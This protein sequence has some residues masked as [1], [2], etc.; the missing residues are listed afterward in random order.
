MKKAIVV[1]DMQNDF[2]TGA[3]RNEDA[4]KMIPRAVAKLKA[5]KKE[6]LPII[7]TRDTHS[8]EG[9]MSSEE[10][11]NLPLP[12]CL[13]GEEGWEI[14]PELKPFTKDA[15]VIDKPGFGSTEL[16]EYL[17]QQDYEEIEMFGLC[18]DICVIANA[19]TVKAF[20]PN[21]HVAVDANCCE[22]ITPE[23]HKTALEAM[24][25]CHIEILGEKDA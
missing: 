22:G 7:F 1:I 17:R 14:I 5:A 23:S 24:K 18:T 15:V 2:V 11:K 10:G 3:L 6:G 16:G 19:M 9:Y 20:L 4:I 13:E 21:A 8:K 25:M 12:H